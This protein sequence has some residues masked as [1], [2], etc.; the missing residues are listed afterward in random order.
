MNFDRFAQRRPGPEP[1][2]HPWHCHPSGPRR[3]SLNEGRGL[4]PGDT[5]DAV[6]E[7]VRCC[8]RSTKAGA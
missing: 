3:R 6:H 1:R 7:V 4:N 5:S 2:R 8:D